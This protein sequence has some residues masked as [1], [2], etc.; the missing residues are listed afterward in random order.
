[1]NDPTLVSDNAP[2]PDSYR[3]LPGNRVGGFLLLRELGEGGFGLVF[4]AEQTEPIR[5]RVALKLIKRGMGAHEFV[6]RFAAERQTLALMDHPHIA[7]VLDAGRSDDGR[8]FLAMELVEGQAITD[9]CERQELD[10]RVRLSLVV[11]VCEA[12]QH[13]HSKGIIHRDLKPSNV[14]VNLQDGRPSAKVID[15]GIA[16]ALGER[17]DIDSA[18]TAIGMLIGTPAY[19]SPEQASGSRDIDT[20]ADIYALG[21]MLYELLTRHTPLDATTLREA[22]VFELQRIISEVEPLSPSERL[23]RLVDTRAGDGPGR[24]AAERLRRQLRGELD[25]I[26]MKAIDKDRSRRY[27]TAH[28]LAADLGRFLDG[29]PVLAAP[30]SAVYRLHKFVRRHA[31]AVGGAG[32]VLLALVIGVGGVVWQGHLARARAADLAEMA[33]FEQEMFSQIDPAAAGGALS[34]DVLDAYT[35]ALQDLIADPQQR[36]AARAAFEQ[37]WRSINATD[38]ARRLIDRTILQPAAQAIEQR[39]AGRP[40]LKADLLLTLADRYATFGQHGAALGLVEAAMSARRQALGERHPETLAARAD[41]GRMQRLA[42]QLAAAEATQREVLAQARRV[43][44]ERDPLTLSAIADL[45]SVLQDRGQLDEAERLI[46]QALT[47][48]RERLGAADQETLESL[49]DLAILLQMQGMLEEAEQRFREALGG[50]RERFGADDANALALLGNLAGVLQDQGRLDE[51]EAMFREELDSNRRLLGEEHPNTLTS[52]N[53]LA[54]LLH[55]RGHGETAIR[56]LGD[57]LT[58]LRGSLGPQHPHTLLT[59][60]NFAR[61]QQ[62]H[63]QTGAALVAAEEALRVSRSLYGNGHQETLLLLDDVGS[64][65][66]SLDRL[67]PAIAHLREAWERR[68]LRAGVSA[69]DTL[70]AALNLTRA[71]NDADQPEAVL[72]LLLPIRAA[73]QEAFVAEDP[74]RVAQYLTETARADLASGRFVAAERALLEARALLDPLVATSPRA[75]AD[76]LRALQALYSGWQ[77]QQPS[78]QRAEQLAHWQSAAAAVSGAEWP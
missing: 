37:A 59:L 51:A 33:A 9:F 54:T 49:N 21:V 6:Q 17:G 52:I 27:Q 19:M 71:L 41:L 58:G 20:R 76:N 74:T 77:R 75:S 4:E 35:Q 8:P 25:W 34:E 11:Q 60:T 44:G 57:A 67:Q 3:D 40:E 56:L 65:L 13:A 63:G 5:R 32:L 48:R 26:I 16:K 29:R 23:G 1:M 2:E 43:H 47:L 7:R 22:N 64:L 24:V 69:P 39:F 31:V 78:R 72:A 55:Q 38:R 12:I 10:V 14:L 53:N 70:L 66:H 28:E 46:R 18:Q 36:V 45:G 68:R 42:G 30:P 62:H 73:I 50:F 61:V 15:F